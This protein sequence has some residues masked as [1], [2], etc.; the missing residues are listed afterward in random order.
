MRLPTMWYVRSAT[1]QSDQSLCQS[2]ESSM[3]VKLLAEHHLE[4][5]SLKVCC[6]GLSESSCVKITHC[7]K[8]DVAAQIII[9][10]NLLYKYFYFLESVL[11]FQL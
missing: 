10:I 8:S 7:W 4:Y 5:L 11:Y 2:L 1:T 9:F 3:T 6:T